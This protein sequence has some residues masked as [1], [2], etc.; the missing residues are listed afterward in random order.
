MHTAVE[1]LQEAEERK[2]QAT[3]YGSILH[4]MRSTIRNTGSGA[5][6]AGGG[7]V[8][9]LISMLLK[10]GSASTGGLRQV[11]SWGWHMHLRIPLYISI[12][13]LFWLIGR[14]SYLG[15]YFSVT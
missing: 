1:Q 4:S 12:C 2:G 7:A 11:T 8:T 5:S 6:M 10:G 3:T 14:W 9:S 13:C 15:A